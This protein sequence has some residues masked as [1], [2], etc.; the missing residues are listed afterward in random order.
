[1]GYGQHLDFG[2]KFAIDDC[3]RKSLEDES[4]GARNARWPALR[5]FGYRR[6][7]AAEFSHKSRSGHFAPFQIP[8]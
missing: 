6:N 5:R 2:R 8:L 1:M 3:I 4:S 7:S